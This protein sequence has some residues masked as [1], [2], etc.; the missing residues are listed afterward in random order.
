VVSMDKT[1]LQAE[2]VST[3]PSPT[4]P[5]FDPL[6]IYPENSLERMAGLIKPLETSMARNSNNDIVD[7]LYSDQ[8]IVSPDAEMSASLPFV[9]RPA[10]LDGT[11]PGDRGFN[12]FNFA[13]NPSALQWQRKA[14]IKHA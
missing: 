14:E 12:P 1:S 2:A 5:I 8:S 3:L 6:G 9:A 11:L 10:L 13:S 7:R 4:N